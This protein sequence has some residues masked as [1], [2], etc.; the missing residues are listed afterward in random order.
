MSQ[1]LSDGDSQ[2]NDAET[3][4]HRAVE[5]DQERERLSGAAQREADDAAGLG[6]PWPPDDPELQLLDPAA[7]EIDDAEAQLAG[8]TS[9]EL[10]SQIARIRDR[11]IE[12]R[13]QLQI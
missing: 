10:Q 13:I 12:A 5:V 6:T 2:V 3:L 4:L 9:V 1:L 7:Y 8:T 11:I